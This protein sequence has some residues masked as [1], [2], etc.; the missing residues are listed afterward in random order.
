MFQSREPA[1]DLDKVD[2]HRGDRKG[3]F[4]SLYNWKFYCLVRWGGW[5]WLFVGVRGFCVS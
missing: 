5:C 4:D 1:A 2:R 3:A